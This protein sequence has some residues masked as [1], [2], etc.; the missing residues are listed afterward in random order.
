MKP[1]KGISMWGLLFSILGIV[2]L[3]LLFMKLFPPYFDNVKIQEGLKKLSLNPDTPRMTR[4]QVVRRLDN[5]L[6]IDF[7]HE[8]V[9]LAKA[10]R[11]TK[12]KTSMNISI[13]YEVVVPLV[14]NLSALI[15]FDNEID[16]P[17]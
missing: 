15:E 3:A 12:S 17:L 4:M 10:V 8:I 7:A 1:Q 5:I 6:Y 13:D 2:I 9:D 14:Y 16:I 11:V